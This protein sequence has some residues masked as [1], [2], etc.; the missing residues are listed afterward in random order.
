VPAS[1]PDNSKHRSK[2]MKALSLSG[3][4]NNQSCASKR[5]LIEEN[6]LHVFPHGKLKST[7]G[8]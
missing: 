1:L 8:Q 3:A 2:S 7:V 6:Q 5:R 4:P